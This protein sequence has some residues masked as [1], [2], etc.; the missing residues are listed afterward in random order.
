MILDAAKGVEAQTKKLF[1]VCRERRIPIFTFINKLD[2]YGKIPLDLLDEIEKVLGIP[3]Y[4]MNFPIGVD[5]KYLGVYDRQK[6]LIELFADDTTHGQTERISEI[7][8]ADDP[9]VIDKIGQEVFNAL[10]DDLMLLDEA[11][12]NF[13]KAKVDA[14]DLTP[15]FFGSAMTNFGVKNFLE[16]YLRLAPTPA[17]RLS[18][19]AENLKE[20]CKFGTHL[21]TKL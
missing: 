14:G 7:F 8:Q 16:E 9:A 20:I 6:N 2:R 1:K 21:Q 4:P 11:G 5:G 17:P 15:T 18:D 19:A 10:Q 13:D 3:T 12:E